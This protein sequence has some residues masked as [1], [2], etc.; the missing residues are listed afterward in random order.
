ML[1]KFEPLMVAN[2]ALAAHLGSGGW[3]LLFEL[4]SVLCNLEPDTLA[5]HQLALAKSVK[6]AGW[7]V[8]CGCY[9]RPV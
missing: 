1:A 4:A 8:C 9:H 5:E 2:H 6:H 3:A 7:A